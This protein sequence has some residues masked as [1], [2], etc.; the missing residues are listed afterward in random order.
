MISEA[1]DDILSDTYYQ[2]EYFD[3][4]LHKN[5]QLFEYTY[6]EG[7]NFIKFKSIK[8][9]IKVVCGTEVEGN[10]FDLET[11]YG[12]G[13]PVSNTNDNGFLLRG[14]RKYK[15]HCRSLNIVSEFIRFHPFNS[16][17]ANAHFFDMHSFDR[18]TVLVDL[19]CET[20]E[21]RKKYSKT[22]RNILK[23]TSK[24]LLVGR[25]NIALDDFLELYDLTMKKN[26]ADKFYYFDKEYFFRLNQLDASFLNGVF[27]D[28]ELVSAGFFM[29]GKEIGHYHLSANNPLLA[30]ENGNYLLL[31]DSFELAKSF[32]LR[33]MML[34][35]GR[36][37]LADDNLLAFKK[38]FSKKVLPFYIAGFDF[39]P[40]KRI[41]LNKAWL[42][43]NPD[44]KKNRQ[45][46]LYRC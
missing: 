23:K 25:N 41:E 27:V 3:L 20:E 2:N 46:Q 12:Y 40:E 36:T 6:R 24:R 5:R 19:D 45:F 35:G 42:E 43:K 4:Y 29:L 44:V 38:K 11:P 17:G 7:D 13:G 18:D 21:R 15:E 28:G 37:V 26:D 16:L 33:Y 1:L 34:G 39:M 9:P 30:K 10:L 22:T 32:G 8:R 14:V 31:D